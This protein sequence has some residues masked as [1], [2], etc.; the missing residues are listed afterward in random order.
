[1]TEPANQPVSQSSKQL[2]E[3]GVIDDIT[4]KSSV[5]TP[6]T[7]QSMVVTYHG[8]ESKADYDVTKTLYEEGRQGG[9]KAGTGIQVNH[10]LSTMVVLIQPFSYHLVDRK[11]GRNGS[12]TMAG[13]E[14]EEEVMM[15]TT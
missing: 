13:E 2:V 1:M 12:T 6:P 7:I 8:I 10:L 5:C 15:M 9:R 3:D 11:E 4:R 14:E